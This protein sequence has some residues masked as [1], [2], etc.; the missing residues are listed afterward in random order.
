MLKMTFVPERLLP[1]QTVRYASVVAPGGTARHTAMLRERAGGLHSE[2]RLN[3]RY[4]A[5]FDLTVGAVEAHQ[6]MAVLGYK[7][8]VFGTYLVRLDDV[9]IRCENAIIAAPQGALAPLCRRIIAL[10]LAG[11]GRRATRLRVCAAPGSPDPV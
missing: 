7:A 10:A 1:G 5:A 3:P 6:L 2:G 9:L 4:R 8:D 11:M